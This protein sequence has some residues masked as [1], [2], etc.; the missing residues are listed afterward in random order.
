MYLE[1]CGGHNSWK[2]R[3]SATM[4]VTLG[5][6]AYHDGDGWGH[7]FGKQGTTIDKSRNEATTAALM[8]ALQQFGCAFGN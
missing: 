3:V 7:G 5:D 6:G 4:R 8:Q 1:D 2:V